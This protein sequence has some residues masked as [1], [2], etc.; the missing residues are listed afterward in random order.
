MSAKDTCAE[1]FKNGK[2]KQGPSCDVDCNLIDVDMGT[3]ACPNRCAEF[4]KVQGTF[5]KILGTLIYYP[6]L[7]PEERALVKKYPKEA[8]QVYKSKE[9]AESA[10]QRVFNRNDQLDESDAFRHF[11]WAATMR[12]EL[13]APLVKRFLDAHESKAIDADPD[14]AMDMANNRAGLL[15]AE[16]LL[17]EKS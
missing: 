16:R 4:C 7:T 3:F 1:W 15:A 17:Q 8:V 12:S 9:I 11:V 6:M 14:K 13:E 5:D 10:T 2:V